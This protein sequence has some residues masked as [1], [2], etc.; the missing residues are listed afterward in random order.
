MK[1]GRE[2]NAIDFFFL[3]FCYFKT[4]EK[5]DIRHDEILY[6]YAM[7]RTIDRTKKFLMNE[8]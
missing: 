7:H 5:F 2:R 8:F 4:E 3:S 1:R 6:T